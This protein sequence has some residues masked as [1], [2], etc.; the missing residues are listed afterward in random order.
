M[1]RNRFLG[2]SFM[3]P[4]LASI[5]KDARPRPRVFLIDHYDAR[6]DTSAVEE[7]DG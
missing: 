6:G 3:K 5:T 2:P 7:V 1:L 4:L